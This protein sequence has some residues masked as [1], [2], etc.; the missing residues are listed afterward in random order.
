MGYMIRGSIPSD[1]EIEQC[2]NS[3]GVQVFNIMENDQTVGGV[4]LTIDEKTNHNSLDL[5]YVSPECHS[6]GIGA[7]AWKEI[8]RR[9]PK[10]KVWET[11]TPYFEQRNI[12]FYVNKCGFHIVEF[13]NK[14]HP[15]E[16]V[17]VDSDGELIPGGEGFFR[18]EKV[19]K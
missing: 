3:D 14:F 11:C 16:S 5:L 15:E 9:Y 8:E 19:M 10:T 7:S 1:E 6:K 13:F 12:H 4:V 18:F 2:F 17:P